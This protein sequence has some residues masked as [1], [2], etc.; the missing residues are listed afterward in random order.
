MSSSKRYSI[1]EPGPE[2]EE[3]LIFSSDQPVSQRD[4]DLLRADDEALEHL[5]QKQSP[6]SSSPLKGVKKFLPKKKVKF[7]YQPL[8]DEERRKSPS[9]GSSQPG[10][11]RPVEPMSYRESDEFDSSESDL[12][13]DLETPMRRRKKSKPVV[14][15][16]HILLFAVLILGGLLF[17]SNILSPL[18]ND[19]EDSGNRKVRPHAKRILS[20]GTHDFYPTTVVV[21]L[22]GFHPHYINEELTPNL[23]ALYTKRTAVPHMIP[24][25]PSSTFPNHWTLVTGLRPVNHGIVGNTFFDPRRKKQFFNTKPG[26]SLDPYWWGGEPIWQTAA[27]HGVSTAVHMWPGSEVKWRQGAPMEVDRFNASELLSAKSERVLGW[28]DRDINTRPELILT[29]A[30]TVDTIGHR[31]GI[32]GEDLKDALSSVDA[33]IGRIRSGLKDRNLSNIINLV[34]VSDHGMAPTSNE[35]LVF[36]DDLVDMSTIAHVDGWPL[37]GLRPDRKKI[38]AKALYDT[39]KKQEPDNGSWKVYQRDEMPK[40]WE[41]GGVGGDYSERLAEVWMVPSV[42]W[43]ITT[44]EQMKKLN[45]QYKPRGVHGYNN[46]EVLMRALFVAEGEYFESDSARNLYKPFPNTAVYNILCDTLHV[47]PSFNDGPSLSEIFTPL[48]EDWK[49]SVR[50]PGVNFEAEVL[51]INSTY[52]DLFGKGEP[53]DITY[54]PEP[55]AANYNGTKKPD[56]GGDGRDSEANLESILEDIKSSISDALASAKDWIK[57]K[58]GGD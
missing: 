44:H 26:Q 36:L 55:G 25:F 28:L 46:T 58:L 4:R 43:S 57:G 27:F 24:S 37:M 35:R 30:P 42:G 32:F 9:G 34:V 15:K 40:E 13:I 12:E 31:Y 22:D 11:S 8:D 16:M 19:R 6:R 17:F 33:L 10:K 38:T 21:S 51:T 14:R 45:G 5:S 23:H 39:L 20:N 29:Y 48:P 47:K 52:E 49:D 18:T 54:V 56:A 53:A 3:D 50:Y 7:D 41:F 2:E 1:D